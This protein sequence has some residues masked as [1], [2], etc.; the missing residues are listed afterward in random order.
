MPLEVSIERGDGLLVRV[1]G[2]LDALVAVGRLHH[3]PEGI[4]VNAVMLAEAAVLGDEHGH[5]VL[6][7]I[8]AV[9]VVGERLDGWFAL[10][11]GEARVTHPEIADCRETC[12][13]SGYHHHD[14][15]K[16]TEDDRSLAHSLT[17]DRDTQL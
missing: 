3:V 10:A 9:D 12:D 6:A 16:S 11:T 8:A 17:A 13:C 1:H 7:Q 15:R 5:D 2:D 4:P 14:Y